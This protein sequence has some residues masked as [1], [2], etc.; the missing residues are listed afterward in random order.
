MLEPLE[1]RLFKTA[2]MKMDAPEKDGRKKVKRKGIQLVHA[3]FFSSGI[4]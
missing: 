2:R 4:N 3:P 1:S